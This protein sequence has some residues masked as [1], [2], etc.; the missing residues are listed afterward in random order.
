MATKANNGKLNWMRAAVAV[1]G[2]GAVIWIFFEIFGAEK[3][4][5][6]VLPDGLRLTL[7]KVSYGD[8]NDYF[9]SGSVL[10]KMVYR[11]IPKSWLKDIQKNP[12]KNPASLKYKLTAFAYKNVLPPPGFSN[13][14]TLWF[15]SNGTNRSSQPFIK[16]LARDENG[17]ASGGG[18]I[19]QHGPSQNCFCAT[20]QQW[21]RRSK[22]L[23]IEAFVRHET[24]EARLGEFRIENPVF[25]SYPVWPGS[26]LPATRTF[27][28]YQATLTA[29][30]AGRLPQNADFGSSPLAVFQITRNGNPDESLGLERVEVADATGNLWTMDGSWHSSNA[31][32]YVGSWFLP[33]N[34]TLKIRAALW[35]RQDFAPE[36]TWTVRDVVW[37]LSGNFTLLTNVMKRFPD[38]TAEFRG[39]GEQDVKFPGAFM[40]SGAP[41]AHFGIT[42]GT[43]ELRDWRMSVADILDEEGKSILRRYSASAMELR[44][45]AATQLDVETKPRRA[46]FVF[47]FS[48]IRTVEFLARATQEKDGV[49]GRNKTQ[50]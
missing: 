40:S 32:H 41:L 22:M 30:D 44:N 23:F 9:H 26:E 14:L 33:T 15:T 1:L 50:K 37:P 13:S 3:K 16:L 29:L 43:N 10:E 6:V 48:K 39:V 46:T 7:A 20:I 18:I 17:S 31:W 4:Q 47:G 35:R 24:K 28:D 8:P 45:G 42:A 38:F 21:P 19:T 49:I 36:D 34:E 25:Q 5:T 2:T 27:G 11:L 12:N